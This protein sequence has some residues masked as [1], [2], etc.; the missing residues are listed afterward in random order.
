M[1]EGALTSVHRPA[2]AWF[3]VA[4]LALAN[5]VS[6]IDRLILSLLVM[7]IKQE[8]GLSDTEIS[9]LQGLAFA[10]FYCVVG[11]AIARLADR[12]SRKWI[13]TAG[14]TLWCLMTA[15]SGFARSYAQ[16]F[17][18]RIGVG[19]GE[20]TLSPSAYSLIAGYFPRE[21]LALAVGVFSA[22]VTAGMGLAFLIGGAAIQWV[23]AQGP[24]I[25]PGL[26]TIDGWRLV[27]LLVGALGLPVAILMLFVREPARAAGF[28]PATLGE[29]IAHLRANLARYGYVFAG[30]G[31][32]S[33]TV[34]A[35]VS[36]TP[37][38]Y[39]RHY[40]ASIPAA[41]TVLGVIAL[42][43]GLA[44]AFAGGA[45]ADRLEQRGD[46]H[47]KLKVLAGCCTGLVLPAFIAPFMPTMQASAAVLWFTF[48]FGS[49]ATGPAGAY[50]QSITPDAMRAQLGACYQLS[51]TLV[52]ATLGPFLT[53]FFTDFVFRDES[54]IGYSL[55][56]VA[57]IANPFAAV[58]TWLAWRRAQRAGLSAHS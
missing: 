40:A 52:G 3:V 25:L 14:I 29:V 43:G 48:F 6:F 47:A 1:S 15:M 35:V 13:I 51:L 50:V 34:F 16:L 28:T 57:A 10:I 19:F 49:A 8:L 18:M 46:P 7:P 44:G 31:A 23:M 53:A 27:F 56:A 26:G 17:L 21:R 55:S 22:G 24:L 58:L 9:L 30:Y 45:L 4:V 12:A 33:I 41:A 32:T 39:F 36:W 5:C 37:T 38:F 11:L 54:A 2:Y 42:T 20:G